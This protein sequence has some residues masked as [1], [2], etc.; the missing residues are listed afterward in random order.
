MR[1]L[2]NLFRRMLG[3]P[4]LGG[5]IKI[6]SV[7]SHPADKEAQI[8][9]GLLSAIN[10]RILEVSSYKPNPHGPDWTTQFYII[11]PEQKISDA[12]ATVLLMKGL[13]N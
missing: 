10:G 3:I 6:S 2:Q 4:E 12:I 5:E 1:S 11:E 7:S 8:R 13:E 9:I